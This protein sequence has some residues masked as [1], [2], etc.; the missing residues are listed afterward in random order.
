MKNRQKLVKC[1]LEF[2]EFV[3]CVHQLLLNR[4]QDII[5]SAYENLERI[6]FISELLHPVVYS[7]AV[8]AIIDV[9]QLDN[10]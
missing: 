2:T 6:D 7:G 3:A 10:I 8:K 5:L 9:V 1:I 4:V